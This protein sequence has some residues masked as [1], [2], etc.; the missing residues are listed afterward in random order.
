MASSRPPQ[1]L[2]DTSVFIALEQGRDIAALP[3]DGQWHVSAVTVG[4]LKRGV[5]SAPNPSIAARRLDTWD[6]VRSS[7]PVVDVDETVANTW[8]EYEAIAANEQRAARVADN[9][10]A[11]TAAT[12][13]LVLV[14]QDRDFQWYPDLEVLLV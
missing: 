8:G 11:A 6:D 2:I 3:S 14:T 5:L 12:Y 10:I 7:I 4:E 9:L 13:G 1:Y